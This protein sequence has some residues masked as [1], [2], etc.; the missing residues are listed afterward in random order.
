MRNG[1]S[2][3]GILPC[4]GIE[5]DD[6]GYALQLS[7]PRMENGTKSDQPGL[8]TVPRHT[9]NGYI[10]GQYPPFNVQDGDHFVTSINCQYNANT[11]NV[12][13]KFEYQVGDGKIK[14]LKE[15]HEVYEGKFL[16]VD[17]DLSSLAG[18]NVKF[19]FSVSAND[20]KGKDEAL[21][22]APRILR[23]GTPSPTPTV[24]AS[25]TVTATA[26]ATLTETPT[27]TNTP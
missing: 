24:T 21:W 27:A 12:V 15:W 10:F 20:T 18:K 2:N 8:L 1:K 19:Y 7:N 5:G 23:Q 22:L 13:L 17:L 6:D 14:T 4:P 9:K 3:R 16:L 25:P 26:T 11:C